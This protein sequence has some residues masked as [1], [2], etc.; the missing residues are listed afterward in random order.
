MIFS[1]NPVEKPKHRRNKPK[2]GRHTA[3]TDKV[4]EEVERRSGGACERCGR[5]R[6][7]HWYEMAH[8][9]NASA[10]GSGRDPWNIAKLCG[11]KTA[12]GTCHQI[13][14]ETA[15][16]KEWKMRKL[17]EL[18]EYYANE[19]REWAVKFNNVP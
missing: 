11:P 8:L 4:R 5:T 17:A 9:V 1:Y 6:A 18:L 19:G 13:A 2:R 7:K 3:I 10:I 12:T 14:D 16:G 15:E